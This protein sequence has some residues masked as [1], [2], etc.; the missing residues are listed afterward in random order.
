MPDLTPTD[1]VNK[2]FGRSLRGYATDEV[3]D[4]LQQA[5]DSLFRALEEGQR[6]RGQIESLN[7]QLKRYQ[8]T[9]NLIK[10]ALVLAE[11]TAEDLRAQAQRDAEQ[12]RRDATEQLRTERAEMETMRHSRL[13]MI[14]ELRALLNA[15]LSLLESQERRIQ[16]PQAPPT[17]E[18]QH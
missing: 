10:N 3:D 17:E 2:E 7:E 14:A 4:F 16:P 15:H 12:I 11:R 5:S 1:I 9:E 18:E 8:Q 13:G 6:L